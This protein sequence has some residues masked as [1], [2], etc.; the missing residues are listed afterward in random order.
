MTQKRQIM[1][2]QQ[3]ETKNKFDCQLYDVY[4]LIRESKR[5]LFALLHSIAVVKKIS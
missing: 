3:I 4:Y 5:L 2:V 1:F